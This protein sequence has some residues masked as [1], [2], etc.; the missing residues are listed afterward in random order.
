LAAAGAA[1]AA[2]VAAASAK[3]D[4]SLVAFMISL[5]SIKPLHTERGYVNRAASRTAVPNVI[6]SVPDAG[7]ESRVFAAC[8]ESRNLPAPADSNGG[9]SC[10]R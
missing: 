6:D 1:I 5:L 4:M 7:A 3:A 2:V 9:A 10:A 8:P